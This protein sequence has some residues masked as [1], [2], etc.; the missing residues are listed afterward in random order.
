MSFDFAIIESDL[1]IQ[2]DGTMRT[3]EDTTKLRQDILKIITTSLGSNKFHPW[4]GCTVSD[5]IIG[6]NLPENLMMMEIETSITESLEN[7]KKL[8]IQQSTSQRISL[9]EL[10][11]TIGGVVAFRSP[12]DPRQVKIQVTVFTKR[13]TKIEET[14][15]LTI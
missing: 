6:K 10:I 13:L 15:T 3:V 9:A 2:P 7:L 1:V 12:D 4:Y 8:Q 11:N 5:N 14:F